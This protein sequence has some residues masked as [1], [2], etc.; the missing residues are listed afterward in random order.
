M[1][2]RGK[3]A[4]A[5]VNVGVTLAAYWVPGAEAKLLGTAGMLDYQ[6]DSDSINQAFV[7]D[8]AF[9]LPAS[10]WRLVQLN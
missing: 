6:Q 4:L 10:E 1:R 8:P 5:L 7:G 9:G 2:T 3:L